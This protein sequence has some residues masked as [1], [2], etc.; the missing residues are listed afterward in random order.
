MKKVVV[1]TLFVIIMLCAFL[2]SCDEK[3]EHTFEKTTY[4]STCSTLG[5]TE[6]RCTDCD[7]VKT[8]Y[9]TEYAAHTAGE[10]ETVSTLSCTTDEI[11]AQKC[12]ACGKVIEQETIT[13]ATG[14]V[15]GEWI[16]ITEA[17][18]KQ[19]GV[20]EKHCLVCNEV[21]QNT[22]TDISSHKAGEWE[23][24][25]ALSCT[26][27]EVVAQKCIICGEVI[28]QE[29]ATKAS[30]HT[31]GE[32]ITVTE[33]TCKQT[34]VKEKHCLVCNAVLQ[35]TSVGVS[36]HKYEITYTTE[37]GK[38]YEVTTCSI[39][40]DTLKNEVYEEASLTPNEIY[41]KISSATV[42]VNCY[43]KN[44]TRYGLGSG[45]FISNDGKIVTNYH[46][47]QG[48]YALKIVTQSGKSYSVTQ[49]LGYSSTEDIA[50]L[51]ISETDTPYLEIATEE[52]KTGDAVYT[53]GSSLGL[54]DTFGAGIVSN[55]SITISKKECIQFTA[56]MSSGN[57]GGPL[58]NSS[59]EVIGIT[60]MSATSGQDMNF[61]LKISSIDKISLSSPKTPAKLYTTLIK[62]NAF[63]ILQKYMLCYSSYLNGTT[64]I[65]P[66]GGI[67]ESEEQ[68]GFNAYIAYDSSTEKLIVD[69][70]VISENRY[71]YII[72]LTISGTSDDYTVNLF[73]YEKNQV[74]LSA[75]AKNGALISDSF[76]NV[77]TD[78]QN[79][80]DPN[81]I[82]QSVD[83]TEYTEQDAAQIL[84]QQFYQIAVYKFKE[85]LGS[86]GTGVDLSYFGFEI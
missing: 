43:D 62:Q 21:L 9:L 51:K 33:A 66:C 22:S 73:D 17:T 81:K 5:Y 47:I 70:Y 84:F 48:A 69:I 34:G 3:H 50:I 67:E 16:T 82:I 36:S 35:T 61:A 68:Y 78:F 1:S 31:E 54:Q 10:W 24:V 45:F 41:N 63:V 57:S 19:T 38:K 39:C 30:G 71:R 12:I 28:A 2:A 27:D 32:W 42:Q 40:G 55:P 4:P 20:K 72:E 65:I 14:H 49:V 6:E 11:A 44:G 15:E 13:K 58:V 26:T 29:T 37:D 18:C 7:M 46:V 25:G 76:E 86:T 56:Q 59:G 53:L 85:F 80:Y 64:Y 8:T 23:T 74:M 60:T 79:K 83:G 75:T 77:F 52:V